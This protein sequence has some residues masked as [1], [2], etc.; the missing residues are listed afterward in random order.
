[1]RKYLMTGMAALAISAAFTSCS[2]ETNVYNPDQPKQDIQATY[3]QNFIKVFGQPAANQDWGFGSGAGTRTWNVNGNQWHDGVNYNYEYDAKVTTDEKNKVFNYVNDK[4]NVETVNQ[5]PYT[6]YWV[7]QIWNGNKDANATGAKAPASISYPNQ[8]GATTTIIGGAQMDKLEIKET[9]SADSWIHCNNFNGADNNDWK[10]GGEG[11]RTL[12]TSSGT[13]SFRYTNS[14]SSYLSEKYII[15]PGEKI[16][17]SLAGFYYVCFDF[18]KGYTDAE[19]AQETTYFT[20]VGVDNNGAEQAVQT[21]SIPGYYTSTNM[22][23]DQQIKDAVNNPNYK[24]IKNVS[25]KGYLYGDKHCDGDDNYTDWIVRISPAKVKSNYDIRIIG[26]DLSAGEDGNDFDFND[27]VFDVKFTGDN[28]AKICIVAAGGTLPLKV[29]DQEVHGLFHQ[30]TNIMINTN[31]ADAGYPNQ[32][33]EQRDNLP[34]FDITLTGV[35][36][37][38][39]KNIKIEVEKEVNGVKQWVELKANNGEPAAK[40]GVKPGFG[41]CNERQGIS[42]KYPLFTQWVQN[43]DVVWYLKDAE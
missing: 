41:Y 13:Y 31:A 11:G 24:E 1:M 18:E 6:E 26:E 30:D 35:K 12:M 39:G 43:V 28:T 19:K 4:N 34:T 2:K 5:I 3:E 33:Y 36:A 17:A 32:A 10:E 40:I 7:T 37:A 23:T 21:F 27:V 16:D 15:V 8:N 38:N 9:Q 20:Y 22:P 29:A 42:S 14:Q 25:V